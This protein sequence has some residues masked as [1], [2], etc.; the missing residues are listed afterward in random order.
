MRT[1]LFVTA[2][3]LGFA[4]TSAQAQVIVLG[5]S[6]A[7][8]CY[9]AAEFGTMGMRDGFEVCTQALNV[10]GLSLRDRAGTFVNRAVIRMRAGDYNGALTDSESGIRLI[11]GLGEAHVNRGAALLNLS[12]PAEALQAIN[13]GV[14]H[15]SSKM[16]L[17]LYNR[18]AAR[19]LTGDIRG[20][21]FDYQESA[22]LNP[23]FT[24]ARDQLMRFSVVRRDARNETERQNTADDGMYEEVVALRGIGGRPVTQQ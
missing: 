16:H 5:D 11:N 17:V 21:Y 2:A 8:T 14:A 22:R 13:T 3:I 6:T 18:G 15:G 7:A 24:L 4:A 23:A 12:R 19:E 10:P 9:Q 1:A 20:A